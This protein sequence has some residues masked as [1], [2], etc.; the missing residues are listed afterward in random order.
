MSLDQVCSGFTQARGWGVVGH[1]TRTRAP[2]SARES[3]TFSRGAAPVRRGILPK[4]RPGR[5]LHFPS[6]SQVSDNF[7]TFSRQ[8]LPVYPRINV[9]N[10]SRWCGVLEW[11]LLC[12]VLCSMNSAEQGAGSEPRAGE[13]TPT[14]STRCVTEVHADVDVRETDCMLTA[15]SH[16]K[17]DRPRVLL[18]CARTHRHTHTPQS[19]TLRTHTHTHTHT[20]VPICKQVACSG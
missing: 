15:L 10:V 11:V 12:G 3:P 19:H 4:A 20:H 8:F 18:A 14:V 6:C 7:F 5:K 13:S 16:I 9:L 17:G 2:V 1:D